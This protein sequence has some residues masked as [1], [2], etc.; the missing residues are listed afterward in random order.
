MTDMD[1]T[2]ER[3]IEALILSE[4]AV[5]RADLDAQSRSLEQILACLDR[6]LGRF[7]PEQNLDHKC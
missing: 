7:E 2:A 5:I 6:I 1:S 3:V 4:I